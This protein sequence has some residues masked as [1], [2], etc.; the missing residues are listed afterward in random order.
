MTT[1]RMGTL[2]LRKVSGRGLGIN[3]AGLWEQTFTST[4]LRIL[5]SELPQAT[6]ASAIWKN[7]IDDKFR[8]FKERFGW[9]V[10]PLYVPVALEVVIK[11]PPESRRNG[12]HDLDNV[13]RTY[14]LIRSPSIA[15]CAPPRSS[16]PKS[17]CTA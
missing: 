9:V 4:P 16:S 15:V 8:M 7:E 6:G 14:S 11:L 10:D 1:L 5:L 17:T 13:L 3:L 12:L 2:R